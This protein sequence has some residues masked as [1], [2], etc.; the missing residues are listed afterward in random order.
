MTLL[1][2]IPHRAG[3]SRDPLY[4]SLPYPAHMSTT[5]HFIGSDRLAYTS[6]V[7]WAQPALLSLNTGILHS[8][9]SHPYCCA[10]QGYYTWLPAIWPG[11]TGIVQLATSHIFMAYMNTTSGYQPYWRGI[12][13]TIFLRI[14]DILLFCGIQDTVLLR[15]TR[16]VQLAVSFT[17]KKWLL[18]K[19]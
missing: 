8:A 4:T 3:L 18:P 16:I 17:W 11:Q 10:M 7:C 14:Q 15:Y 2:M 12:Q 1:H 13:D 19:C 5:V 9:T 6:L